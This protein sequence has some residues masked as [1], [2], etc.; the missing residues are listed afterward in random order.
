MS[1]CCEAPKSSQSSKD[2]ISSK[3]I[4]KN[5][6]FT[7]W[8]DSSAPVLS[9]LLHSSC[10]WLPTLLDL[11]SIGSASA[12]T[13]SNLR[14]VFLSITVLILLDSI[15]RQGF[16]RHN[17]LRILISSLVLFIPRLQSYYQ[18]ATAVETPKHSCH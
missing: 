9:A 4:D 2:N 18:Q 14:P 15:R 7:S 13:V 17:L 8:I 10:C 3:S 12:A 11:T 16:N 6:G 5:S 1:S